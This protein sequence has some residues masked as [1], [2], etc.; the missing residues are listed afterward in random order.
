MCGR[1]DAPT[2]STTSEILP[3]W[4]VEL[5]DDLD[6]LRAGW[7]KTSNN[8][9]RSL[10][11]A[12]ESE[13]G[14]REVASGPRPAQRPRAVRAH[15][16]GGTGR[17][18]A[19]CASSGSRATCSGRTCKM[20]I[21]AAR[22]G[23][24]SPPACTTCSATRSSWST[25]AATSDAL[26]HASQPCALLGRDALGARSAG[27]R[28]IDL[29]GAYADT[30]LARFKQQ[31]GAEPQPRFRLDHRAGGETTRAESIASIGYGAEGSES[32]LVD[33]AW[34]HV[35]LTAAARRRARR[36]PVRMSARAVQIDPLADPRW[37]AY[38]R[39]HPRWTVYQLGA[40]AEILRRAYRFD[41]RYLALEDDGGALR[42][43]LPA[44]PQEG[45]RVGRA[46]AVAAGVP[47]GRPAR[48]HARGRGR[49]DRGGARRDS[50][51]RR[52]A[53]WR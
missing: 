1:L 5:P 31:W 52:T 12:D 8:L 44:A 41:P 7:R 29:G 25:T 23:A 42:G 14:F 22:P 26:E 6:A 13:L 50:G 16:C 17:C 2:G 37:D 11:K 40:W 48:R 43:V 36:L 46:R 32:R 24:T 3:R 39:A 47:R 20:F 18:R 19:R 38:V 49:A 53:R 51:E 45:P 10:K 34:R 35:P 21:V 4:V 15:A 33:F 30:P 9:F 27:L 28:R